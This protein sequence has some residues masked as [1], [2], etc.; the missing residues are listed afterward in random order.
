MCSSST[1]VTLSKTG[2][3]VPGAERKLRS[4]SHRTPT[5]ENTVPMG[6][7]KSSA[8]PTS[9][10]S[11]EAVVVEDSASVVEVVVVDDSE[12]DSLSVPSEVSSSDPTPESVDADSP[13]ESEDD[14]VE[15]PHAAAAKDNAK[16]TASSSLRIGLVGFVRAG[17]ASSVIVGMVPSLI[18]L[19][20]LSAAETS[21]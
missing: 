3:D 17:S 18:M 6:G 9:S 12:G 15:D 7:K 4:S 14:A 19:V 13:L 16:R 8:E 21:P 5:T 2:F 10:G 11:V 1:D 20:Y